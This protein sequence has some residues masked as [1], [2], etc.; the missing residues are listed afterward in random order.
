MGCRGEGERGRERWAWGG[1]RRRR[2]F[3]AAARRV[4]KKSVRVSATFRP[5]S[6]PCPPAYSAFPPAPT[7]HTRVWCVC[8]CPPAE[9]GGL[10]RA[11]KPPTQSAPLQVW[12]AGP[13]PAFP[14]FHSPGTSPGSA[15]APY[16]R[17]PAATAVTARPKKP[18]DRTRTTHHAMR[19]CLTVSSES[20]RPATVMERGKE[21]GAARGGMM[22]VSVIEVRERAGDGKR[23]V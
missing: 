21:E 19:M 18:E 17:H 1:G 12:H 5:P 4:E 3:F 15:R 23:E 13:T 10:V 20:V 14:H 16:A 9:D 11:T 2:W 8:V 7:P 22:R 6:H